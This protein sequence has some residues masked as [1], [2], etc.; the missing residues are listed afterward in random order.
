MY[1]KWQ[2]PSINNRQARRL[3]VGWMNLGK[4]ELEKILCCT[5]MP[6]IEWMKV[7]AAH[8]RER[9]EF[10]C[11]WHLLEIFWWT[12]ICFYMQNF[13]AHI[14]IKSFFFY[15]YSIASFSF[16]GITKSAN[17][18]WIFANL[19]G[20]QQET[21][22]ANIKK[23]QCLI[24]TARKSFE[25]CNIIFFLYTSKCILKEFLMNSTRSDLISTFR[26]FSFAEAKYFIPFDWFFF[27]VGHFMPR[28]NW[29]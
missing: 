5:F 6:V 22:H 19:L 20:K 3:F 21:W 25:T 18:H 1:K 15:N 4:L 14:L 16:D 24:L 29:M 12:F 10:S 23:M 27:F 28:I 26:L 2:R 9:F 17:S 11:I 8:D 7:K 13:F